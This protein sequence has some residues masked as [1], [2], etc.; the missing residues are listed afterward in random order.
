MSQGWG[1]LQEV[2]IQSRSPS[3]VQAVSTQTEIGRPALFR[4]PGWIPR[5]R[6]VA[7]LQGR[8]RFP[9]IVVT[10]PAGYGKTTA[11]AEWTDADERQLVWLT[12]DSRHDDPALLV[13]SIAA[14]LGAAE[15]LDDSVLAPL[16]AP[17]PDIAGVMVPRLCEA[18]GEREGAVIVLDD[19]HEVSGADS[20]A[21]IVAFVERM[22][23]QSQIVLVSRTE[24]AVGLGRLRG[25]GRL[26]SLRA[27]ELS[28][29]RVGGV[30]AVLR[31]R[32]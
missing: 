6:L 30:T 9:C 32:S 2:H 22:P 3:R 29:T 28:M 26:S 10:A 14:A 1:P 12:L 4:R 7:Q 11:V 31:H 8:R 27:S 25:T 20:L 16:A 5:G 24:P 21:A 17:E 23:E 13:G 15:P 19:L 18:M